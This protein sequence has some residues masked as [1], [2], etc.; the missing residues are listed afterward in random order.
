MEIA[1]VRKRVLQTIDL[2]RRAAA[3]RHERVDAAGREYDLFLERVATPIFRQVAN[4]LRAE[5]HPWSVSTP[6]GSVR[7]SPDRS[8]RD[9]IEL[10][11][12]TTGEQPE[13]L[14]HTSRTRGGRVIETE[15]PLGAGGPVRDLA[16]DTVLQFVLQELQAF[17]ER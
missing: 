9:Y 8:P 13:V 1:D 15:H 7:L 2:A 6:S 3:E 10:A 14:G 17:V 5:G 16:E 11:L 12:D 4:V